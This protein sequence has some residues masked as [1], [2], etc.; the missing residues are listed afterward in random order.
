M[1][2]YTFT[3][4]KTQ[5]YIKRYLQEVL[6][7][8]LAYTLY[9][10]ITQTKYDIQNSIRLSFSIGLF[11]LILEE[12][13]PSYKDSVKSGLNFSIAKQLFN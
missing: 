11:T 8:F 5:F 3:Y 13:N 12:Y 7:A 9:K 6:E 4:K 1:D 2:T 10:F